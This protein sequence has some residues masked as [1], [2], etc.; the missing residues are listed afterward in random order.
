[1]KTSGCKKNNKCS[2]YCRLD[3][4][5]NA[6]SHSRLSHLESNLIKDTGGKCTEIFAEKEEEIQQ[7]NGTYIHRLKFIHLAELQGRYTLYMWAGVTA[8]EAAAQG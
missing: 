1:M 2:S 7:T 6:N 4:V 3:V 5:V 8:K